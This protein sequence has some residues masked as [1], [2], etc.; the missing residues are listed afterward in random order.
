VAGVFIAPILEAVPGMWTFPLFKAFA[1][2]IIGGLG[3][4]EGAIIAGMLLGYT[5]TSV[6]ILLSA[7]YTDM[8][9]LLAMIFILL[10]RPTGLMSK[11]FAY[12]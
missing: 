8:V 3:S 5:E 2:V 7:N 12:K 9:Y 6:S 11:S 4:I 1:I 10:L